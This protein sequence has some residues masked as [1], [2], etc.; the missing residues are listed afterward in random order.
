MPQ[1]ARADY[2]EKP[3]RRKPDV[4]LAA[5]S[6]ALHASPLW[7]WNESASAS[8]RNTKSEVTMHQALSSRWSRA[9]VVLGL[10]AVLAWPAT[11]GAQSVSGFASAAQATVLG[12][13]TTLAHTGSLA[14]ENDAR[15]AA[16]LAGSI[17]SVLG[18]EVLH[19]TTISAIDSVAS[20]ASL[21]NLGL[22][23]VGNAISAR[24]LMAEA[25]APV[26]STPVGSAAV[27]G[28]AV[29][30]VPVW[31]SG[32]PNQTISLPGATLVLNA[33]ESSA[34]GIT[35]SA[36][37]VTSWDGLTDVAVATAMAGISSTTTSATGLPGLP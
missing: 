5:I 28:L 24:F 22:T 33:V 10:V 34:S 30:G 25:F 12:M 19:A 16:Q 11:S 18:A 26:G 31:V 32:E 3:G 35:V 20:E 37:K 8:S 21:A 27:N 7:E 14:D 17:P 2:P 15:G 6:E 9:A 29:N 13:S 4:N 1:M 23:V 36:L